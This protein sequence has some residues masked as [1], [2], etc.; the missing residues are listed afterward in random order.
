MKVR[1]LAAAISLSFVAIISP[2]D[3]A[4]NL[5]CSGN[6]CRPVNESSSKPSVKPHTKRTTIKSSS[7]SMTRKEAAKLKLKLKGNAK[8]KNSVP[9]QQAASSRSSAAYKN[10]LTSLDIARFLAKSESNMTVIQDAIDGYE[11]S[12][13]HRAVVDGMYDL[14][15]DYKGLHAELKVLGK[16][17]EERTLTAEEDRTAVELRKKMN[18]MIQKYNELLPGDPVVE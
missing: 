4:T 14:L 10:Q 1:L 11:K 9:T 17:A 12:P 16:Y 3:A 18:D 8:A 15:F 6:K 13:S 7:S 2:V 5:N